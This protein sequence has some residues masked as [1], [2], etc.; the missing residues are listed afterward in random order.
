MTR[1]IALP[2]LIYERNFCHF[3]L[4]CSARSRRGCRRCSVALRCETYDHSD[5]AAG[6]NDFEIIA[7]L[8]VSDQESQHKTNRQSKQDPQRNR[9]HFAREDSRSDSGDEA[10]YRGSDDDA[11]ELGSYCGCEPRRGPVDSAQQSTQEQS[12]QDLVHLSASPFR[13]LMFS[14]TEPGFPLSLSL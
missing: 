9:I 8:H 3:L 6:K 10:L 7:V 2:P 12:D 5:D 11:R 13:S 1:D 4:L 14:T